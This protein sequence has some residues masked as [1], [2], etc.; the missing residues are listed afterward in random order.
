MTGRM[1]QESMPVS[2]PLFSRFFLSSECS[3]FPSDM[4]HGYYWTEPTILSGH[5]SS[6]RFLQ[7]LTL[8]SQGLWAHFRACLA[9]V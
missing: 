4:K 1:G 8:F 3:H 9:F 7:N 2:Y 6:S 5:V